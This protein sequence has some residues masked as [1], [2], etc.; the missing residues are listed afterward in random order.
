KVC[1]F[2][3]FEAFRAKDARFSTIYPAHECTEID[4]EAGL[5]ALARIRS[6]SATGCSRPK[7]AAWEPVHR[8]IRLPIV[9][10]S[11]PVPPGRSPLHFASTPSPRSGSR[12]A[13]F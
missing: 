12:A 5:A 4:H 13:G 11:A 9:A 10:I 3:G 1:E 7:T 6:A 8:G 2:A